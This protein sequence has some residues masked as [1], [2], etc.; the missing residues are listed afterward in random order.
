MERRLVDGRC[1]VLIGL[2]Y[3]LL[4]FIEGNEFDRPSIRDPGRDRRD[5][6]PL[7]ARA[8]GR[9]RLL[10]SET[11][12]RDGT[13]RERSEKHVSSVERFAVNPRMHAPADRDREDRSIVISKIG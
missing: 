11:R 9:C 12:G 7:L 2:P 3:L 4:H 10:A 1:G 5:L 8:A 13:D 6:R